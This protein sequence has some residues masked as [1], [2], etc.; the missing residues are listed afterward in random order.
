MRRLL[1][2]VPIGV[3][4]FAGYA[5][6]FRAIPPGSLAASADGI[7]RLIGPGLTGALVLSLGIVIS[8]FMLRSAEK[9]R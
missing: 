6:S 4:G 3:F 8:W 2:L 5:I 9:Q 7:T 1:T